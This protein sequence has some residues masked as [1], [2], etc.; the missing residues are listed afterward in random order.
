[1]ASRSVLAGLLQLWTCAE[2]C[3]DKS[4]CALI[5]MHLLGAASVLATALNRCYA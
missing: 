5:R 1:M 3:I 2:S 4:C